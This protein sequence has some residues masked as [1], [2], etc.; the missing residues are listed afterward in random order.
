VLIDG[1]VEAVRARLAEAPRV[2]KARS[3]GEVN[4]AVV[5][6]VRLRRRLDCERGRALRRMRDCSHHAWL[7]YARFDAYVEH[8]LGLSDRDASQLLRLEPS[9]ERLPRCGEALRT[10]ELSRRV[11]AM[12]RR[13]ARPETEA[14]WVEHAKGTTC[15][16]LEIEVPHHLWLR[17]QLGA[18]HYVEL[19]AGLPQAATPVRTMLPDWRR[20]LVAEPREAAPTGSF[21]GVA[22]ATG[23]RVQVSDPSATVGSSWRRVRV[24]T[25]VPKDV[26]EHF[27]A[28]GARVRGV[29]GPL[30]D[31]GACL[32]WMLRRFA[33][34]HW[35]DEVAK[36]VRRHEVQELA[37]W[38]CA[39][40]HCR[41]RSRFEEH[42]VVWRSHG[43][44]DE[45][46]NLANEC[47]GCHHR[48]IHENRMT[49][50][51]RAPDDLLHVL[52]TGPH[53]QAYRNEMRVPLE[54]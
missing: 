53:R 41:A 18:A 26:A 37:G 23:R 28:V 38:L 29:L 21:R 27:G 3:A 8:A 35:N 36:L 32:T 30:A 42:H 31:A 52:G 20:V 10:G 45:I 12:L 5:A 49:V 46:A 22:Q 9:L 43:G 2:A 34:V 39:S 4:E 47:W 50:T 48:L 51:G 1:V 25:W 11:V 13:V 54:S 16:R 15:K 40:P 33:A 6:L 7:G 17:H 19:T 44:F 24:T 14:A